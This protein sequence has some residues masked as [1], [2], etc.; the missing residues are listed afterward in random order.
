M[1]DLALRPTVIEGSHY[2]DG[3]IVVWK[4]DLVSRG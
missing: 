1:I 4:S 2:K 3:Y